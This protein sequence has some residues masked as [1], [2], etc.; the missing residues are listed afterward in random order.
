[1][2]SGWFTFNN[3][4]QDKNYINKLA[5]IYLFVISKLKRQL[6]LYF[7]FLNFI[8]CYTNFNITRCADKIILPNHLHKTLNTKP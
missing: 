4:S 3:I 2:L 1:M 5:W 7:H 8:P 6:G